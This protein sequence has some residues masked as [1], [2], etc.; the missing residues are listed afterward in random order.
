MHG[1]ITPAENP[2][3]SATPP[4]KPQR[5]GEQHPV[6]HE[7]G[8]PESLDATGNCLYSGEE[9]EITVADLEQSGVKKL[10]CPE[11]GAAWA[12]KM[13][14]GKVYFANH[15]PPTRKRSKQPTRG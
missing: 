3:E 13:K 11:C 6:R 12:A 5:A 9:V 14:G 2:L 7:V 1:D 4:T 10:Q 15:P 8:V